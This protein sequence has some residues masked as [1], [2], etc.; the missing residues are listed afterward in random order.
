MKR[1]FVQL[2]LNWERFHELKRIERNLPHVDYK[3]VDL[4]FDILAAAGGQTLVNVARLADYL[5]P[6]APPVRRRP[7]RK[8]K[9]DDQTKIHAWFAVE[10][11]VRLARIKEPKIGVMPAMKRV[12]Q[13]S[14]GTFHIPWKGPIISTSGLAK[15]IHDEG[16]S[17]LLKS[18]PDVSKMWHEI[19][20]LEVKRRSA[21]ARNLP[22]EKTALVAR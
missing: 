22:I 13:K 5:F 10:V 2:Q 18:D 4:A 16:K 11:E 8:K 7:G 1:T 9:W 17:F 21:I 15:R 19:V 14:R 6:P 20:D 3:A 12:L